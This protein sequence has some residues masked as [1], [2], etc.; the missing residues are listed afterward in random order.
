MDSL[1]RKCSSSSFSSH[2]RNSSNASIPSLMSDN[3]DNA[4]LSI[5]SLTPEDLAKIKA[6][7]DSPHL[8]R[9]ASSSPTFLRGNFASNHMSALPG[10]LSASCSYEFAK[11]PLGAH[12]Q[13]PDSHVKVLQES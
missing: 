10:R 1:P 9:F 12:V 6:I 2:F 7:L 8:P 13:F 4:P 3:T 11:Y 5:S